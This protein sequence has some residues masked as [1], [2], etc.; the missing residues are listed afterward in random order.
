MI[1]VGDR[2]SRWKWSEDTCGW[3]TH[4]NRLVQTPHRHQHACPHVP[5]I[6]GVKLCQQSA[7]HLFAS[8]ASLSLSDENRRIHITYIAPWCT[9]VCTVTAIYRCSL[10]RG[11]SI[12]P[13]LRFSA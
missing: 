8:T 11:R 5:A 1:L 7:R 12:M 10:E 9:E 3:Q 2:D 13:C 6:N 4:V